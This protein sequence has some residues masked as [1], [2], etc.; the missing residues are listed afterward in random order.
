MSWKVVITAPPIEKVGQNAVALLK[1]AGCEVVNSAILGSPG[2]EDVLKIIKD[3]DAVIAGVEKYSADVFSVPET[4]RL[5]LISRWGVGFDAID[6]TSATREGILITYTPGMTDES[7]ADYTMGLLLAL[8]RRIID[9][10]ETMSKGLWQPAWGHDMNGKT[11]GILG[12]GRIGQAVARRAKGF[13]LEL[14]AH[15]PHPPMGTD[16]FG[17]QF[18]S[19]NEL[20]ERS[21]YLSLHAT[22]TSSTRDLIGEA[23]LQKMKPS[24]YLINAARGPLVNEQALIRA[25]NEGW[26]AGAALDAFTVEPLPVDHPFRRTPNLLL[27]P[28]QASSSRESG[29]LISLATAQ[30]VLDLMAGK[31]PKMPL[32]SEVFNSP[33]LRAKLK[34]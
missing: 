18:V 3:A 4:K 33:N 2:S 31:K 24:A 7:V 32:N 21:D 19:F 11:L 20:L 16:Q 10:Y 17:T 26:I 6:V 29:E 15:D 1:A 9:G 25:L 13:G 28:H 8:V 23:Q 27:S 22:L 30:A 5:K 12:Y 14:I 34:N